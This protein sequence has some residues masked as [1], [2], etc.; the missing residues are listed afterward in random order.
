MTFQANEKSSGDDIITQC[1][2]VLFWI[3]AAVSLVFLWQSRNLPLLDMHGFRQTQTAISALWM[4]QEA[5][6]IPY[7]TPVF[8]HPWF[9]PYEFP[10]YQGLAAGLSCLGVPLDLS[11]RIVSYVFF[12]L[13]L[14]SVRLIMKAFRLPSSLFYVFGGLYLSSPAYLFWG[15][16][17]L[18]ETTALF[19]CV[20]GALILIY[21]ARRRHWLPVLAATAFLTVGTLVK[22]TTSPQC[23]GFGLAMA[24]LLLFDD[25]T[26]SWQKKL[27]TFA[28]LLAAS[29]LP[30]LATLGWI[31]YCDAIKQ[32]GLMSTIHTSR[33]LRS[34]YSPDLHL[35]LKNADL[36]PKRMFL[37]LVGTPWVVYLCL[38]L[39]LVGGL[40]CFALTA[41]ALCCFF[42]P[43]LLFTRVHI[44]HNYYQ[45]SN[46]VFLVA[47]VALAV[48]SLTRTKLKVIVPI[49]LL[50]CIALN[51]LFFYDY[52]YKI[53]RDT[54]TRADTREILTLASAVSDA[55]DPN[56][57][58]FIFGRDWS[59][60]IPY[61]SQRKAVMFPFWLPR[62]ILKKALAAPNSLT[63]TAPLQAILFC[64]NT[65]REHLY[66]NR[67]TDEFLRKEVAS[68]EV[69]VVDGCTLYR[70]R[71]PS[72][73]DSR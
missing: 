20:T 11:G 68:D 16:A 6:L 63:G 10:L 25:D 61:Y 12:V 65:T 9:I 60:E 1:C 21:A 37:E 26:L 57:V 50:V 29:I 32:A 53:F 47:A 70:H 48:F 58:V 55:S 59:A 2:A 8:G 14:V 5:T 28:L 38:P 44:V 27:I 56:G 66:Y 49:V 22:G 4:R 45:V 36:L 69:I 42:L 24:T 39:A 34:W 30:V 33:G 35:F 71:V 13:L 3:T 73:A 52:F 15:R 67:L 7:Q 43:I 46:G 51:Y 72:N 18:I 40:R 17:F 23:L 19:F 64:P 62:Q 41:L 54:A 31:H